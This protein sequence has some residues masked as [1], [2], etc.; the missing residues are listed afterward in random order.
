MF[1]CHCGSQNTEV[2]E[3]RK[4]GDEG[5]DPDNPDADL[6]VMAQYE[7]EPEYVDTVEQYVCGDCRKTFFVPTDERVE[8]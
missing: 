4:P 7:N 2:M 5:Y 6:D 3:K 1:C 8:R